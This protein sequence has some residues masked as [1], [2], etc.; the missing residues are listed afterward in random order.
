MIPGHCSIVRDR[1]GANLLVGVPKSYDDQV[2][3]IPGARWDAD[4]HRWLAPV[5]QEDD[6]RAAVAGLAISYAEDPRTIRCPVCRQ[7]LPQGLVNRRE[8]RH[9]KCRPSPVVADLDQDVLP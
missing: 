6:L 8:G 1:F 9:P 4:I 5:A 2:E 3:A 7:P